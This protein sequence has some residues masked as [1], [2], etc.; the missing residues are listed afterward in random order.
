MF[1]EA[2]I[3]L[4][5]KPDYQKRKLKA[6]IFDEYRCKNTQQNFSHPSSTTY[7]K[8]IHHDQVGFI[9]HSQGWF[10]LHKSID[11]IHNINKRKVK[12]HMTISIDAEKPF[13]KIQHPFM[14]RTLTK[15]S[16]EGTYLNKIKAIHD[17]PTTNII[18]NREKLNTSLLKSG[19]RMY[20]F[21][22]L[23]NN[24]IGSPSPK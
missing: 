2:T 21:T 4:I 9:L 17:K 10:D 20:T 24:S 19:T 23:F 16:I 12:I 5:P 1:Y 8:I 3:T 11:V 6:N 13:D 14:I 22:I 7:Q 15:V 18:L